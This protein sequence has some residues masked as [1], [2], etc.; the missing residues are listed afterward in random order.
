MFFSGFIAERMNIRYF[1]ATGMVLSGGA[2]IFFGL[3][4]Y[5]NVHSIYYFICIQIFFG[6]VQSSSWPGVVSV[7]GNW[8]GK[9]KRGLIMG[10]WMSHT[11]IGNIL[12][13]L[14]AGVFVS[15]N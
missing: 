8:F 14:I 6:V 1:L 4:S 2:C 5:L 3:A 15:S 7:M 9:G 13:S 10:L 11:S 12:G